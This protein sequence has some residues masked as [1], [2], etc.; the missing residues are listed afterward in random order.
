MNAVLEQ[1]SLDDPWCEHMRAG[2]FSTAWKISD[3]IMHQRSGVPCWDLPRH[4]QYLWDG[5]LLHGRRVLVH[6]YH[7]LGDTIQ[8]VRYL[9]LVKAVA[10]RVELWAQPELIPLLRTARGIDAIH[11]L[12]EQ[13]PETT[14]DLHIELMELPHV[15]RSTLQTIP[16]AV[17]Y[18]HAPCAKPAT[19]R[20]GLNVG[21]VWCSGNWDSRRSVAVE[22]LAPLAHIRGVTLHALQRG[23][24]LL[25]WPSA[26]GPISGKDRPE[27]AA[28]VMRSLDLVISVD[29]M[30]AHLAGALGVPVWTLLCANSDWRWMHE[31]EDC[32]WYPTMRLF[33][34]KAAGDWSHPIGAITEKLRSLAASLL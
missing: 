32:P 17:P 30:P 16:R 8:F 6:C 7:G 11:P 10:A 22:Q 15:F 5:Q 4:K 33:R 13:W 24:A 25:D 23:P 31:R 29:S 3:E 21:V 27:E 18:L 34:Q 9:P 20:F 2:D 19:K 12:A 28:A 14:C 1:H 26:C